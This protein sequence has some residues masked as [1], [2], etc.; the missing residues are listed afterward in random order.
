MPES[1]TNII[2]L[3][4]NESSS[5]NT[6]SKL[7]IKSY[8]KDLELF[9][10]FCNSEDKTNMDEINLKVVKKFIAKSYSAG[11]SASTISRR[12][13]AIR[14]FFSYAHQHNFLKQN[15]ISYLKNPKVK[16][17]LPEILSVNQFD[18]VLI[19]I[20][21]SFSN[22]NLSFEKN[23]HTVIFELLY[24]CSLR[25]SEV[26][27]IL[28][29]NL[30]LNG[31]QLKILGKGNKERIVP[32]GEKSIPNLKNYL[33]VRKSNIENY[34]LLTKKGKRIY[35]RLVQRIVSKYLSEVT[36][37]QKKNPHLLRHSS[38]THLLDNGADLLAIKEIL[39]HSNLST[40][41]IYT[42]TSIERLKKVYK[43]SHPK[44]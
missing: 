37:L 13:S 1:I 30:D 9:L 7:T 29:Q 28:I 22:P 42:H 3:F 6:Y 20:E 18:L 8:R 11:L 15:Y 10:E 44:S 17:K 32:I 12:L 27:N 25:V 38:A 19:D 35:P 5:M 26:C 21:K 40:T 39:G 31:K 34:L 24:G 16:R 36:S 14:S 4:F 33:L 23:L 43:Q 2:D 41:Q